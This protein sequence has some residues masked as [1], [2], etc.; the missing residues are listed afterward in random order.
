MKKTSIISLKNIEKLFHQHN[1][2]WPIFR[3]LNVTFSQSCSY[4]IIGAS[5][6]GKS[7][8]LHLLAGIDRPTSGTVNFNDQDVNTLTQHAQSQFFALEVGFMFQKAHLIHELT[9]L[10]N[11]LLPG[12]IAGMSWQAS[13][14]HALDLL[15]QMHIADKS[16]NLPW[17]LS[18]G[19]QQRAVLARA[20]FNKPTFLLADEPTGNLDKDTGAHIIDLLLLYKQKY[21]MG[22][23]IST[24]DSSLA[25]KMDYCFQIQNGNLVPAEKIIPALSLENQ[26][27]L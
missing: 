26:L 18:G 21:N 15:A 10:E 25:Q 12:L 22:L 8:L 20:L 17:Q 23:I 4:A 6:S 24:H 19:Q 27:A 7:T 2:V 1:L 9:I 14:E 16:Q 5:G 3:Q 11:T 13:K